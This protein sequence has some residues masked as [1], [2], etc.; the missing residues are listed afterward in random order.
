MIMNASPVNLTLSPPAP[1][2]KPSV[3]APV[4]RRAPQEPS[5]NRDANNRPENPKS[6]PRP[7]ANEDGRAR[8]EI[9]N[10]PSRDKSST[11]HC[12]ADKKS[13]GDDKISMQDATLVAAGIETQVNVQTEPAG[14]STAVFATILQAAAQTTEA[15][16]SDTA[17]TKEAVAAGVLVAMPVVSPEGKVTLGR[18]APV[19]APVQSTGPEQTTALVAPVATVATV[20]PIAPIARLRIGHVTSCRA[21]S[22]A[23]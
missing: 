5:P 22:L 13:S 1:T 23:E 9:S 4:D 16:T 6:N 19:W 21:G 8:P 3:P 11:N 14:G 7:S 17:K 2:P 15:P 10:K 18:T 20:A 12:A